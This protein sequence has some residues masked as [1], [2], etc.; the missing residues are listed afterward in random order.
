[1][2]R[3]GGLQPGDYYVVAGPSPDRGASDVQRLR[4][5]D[6]DRVLQL[7]SRP[8]A[9]IGKIDFEEPHQSFAPVFF[10]GFTDFSSAQRITL[11]LAE[12]RAGID[13]RLQL[14]PTARIDGTVTRSDGQQL[15][16]IQIV[17]SAFTEAQSMDL[18]SPNALGGANVDEQ[19]RFS[20]PAVPPGRYVVAARSG[21]GATSGVL[22]A[23]AEV[24]VN[25]T[26]QSV[27]LVMQPG[28]IV[29]GT[30]RFET[31]TEPA[32]KSSG[33]VRL[34]MT[35]ASLAPGVSL[36]VPA[37]TTSTN[38]SFS[39]LGVP[40]G[41]YRLS[42]TPAVAGLARESGTSGFALRSAMHDGVDL[43]DVPLTVTGGRDVND[44]ILTFTDRPTELAGT[45][46]TPVGTPTADYF[47]IVFARDKS[48][49]TPSTRRS[50]MARPTSAGRYVIRN[51]PPG[52]YLVAAVTDVEQG[53][54]FDPAFLERL[55]PAATRL[56]LAESEKKT[57]DLRIQ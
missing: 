6:V 2:Y 43:L 13:I 11:A 30:A 25:G 1:M 9:E 19:G 35:S 16:A 29:S 12:E 54:W 34:T 39:F 49:W 47:I 18:F 44:I 48:F 7:L 40:P 55:V 51:L 17:A 26:D 8:G 5:P 22:W 45:L 23:A 37:V 28:M 38:G 41:P 20:Y 33:G 14:V 4:T 53:D 3:L 57:L 15:S 36:G 50:V 52:E 56:T 10:P 24:S 46:Q 32:P 31:E 27:A 42:A 21:A